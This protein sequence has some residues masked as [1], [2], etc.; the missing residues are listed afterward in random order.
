MVRV[1]SILW[2]LLLVVIFR[3]NEWWRTIGENKRKVYDDSKNENITLSNLQ[4][5][6]SPLNQPQ[7]QFVAAV[8]F[9][10]LNRTLF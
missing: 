7:K 2:K 9:M 1:V 3:A 8:F 6:F 4:T 10:R 5:R